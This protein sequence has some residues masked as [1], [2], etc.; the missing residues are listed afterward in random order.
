M[1]FFRLEKSQVDILKEDIT[2]RYR[3]SRETFQ[4]A[5]EKDQEF[6][7]TFSLSAFSVFDVYVKKQIIEKM[8][9]DLAD[10]DSSAKKRI[11]PAY[12]LLY[13]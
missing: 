5:P 4:D 2:N 8:I 7:K 13:S 1:K 12:S 9:D 6:L 3:L 10:A 11:R